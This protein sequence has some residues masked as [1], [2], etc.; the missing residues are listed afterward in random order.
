MIDDEVWAKMILMERNTTLGKAYIR[1][2]AFIVDGSDSG[3]DG[4]RVGL[5]GFLRTGEDKESL[6]CKTLIEEGCRLKLTQNG[7]ILIKNDDNINIFLYKSCTSEIVARL[8]YGLIQRDKTYKLFDMTKFQQNLSE[9]L[10]REE[11]NW[12]SLEQQ[13]RMN[14]L[15]Q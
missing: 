11:I 5:N 4:R 8:P 7:D 1:S 12:S 6:M 13:V 14:N 2:P 15:Y 10:Q 9:E 3:F